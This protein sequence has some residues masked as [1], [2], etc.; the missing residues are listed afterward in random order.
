[1]ISL[2]GWHSQS[3]D[4]LALYES[5]AKKKFGKEGNKQTFKT[6]KTKQMGHL[7]MYKIQLWC[8][9]VIEIRIKV[10]LFLC[11]CTT[12]GKDKQSSDFRGW[13]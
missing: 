12:K 10:G 13:T 11:L 1:M 3:F 9:Q 7:Q 4:L 5:L 2:W 8:R 6:F